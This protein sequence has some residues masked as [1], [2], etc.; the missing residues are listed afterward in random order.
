MASRNLKI[1]FK[2]GMERDLPIGKVVY[3]KSGKPCIYFDKM[4]NGT[5]RVIVNESIIPDFDAID[6]IELD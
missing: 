6:T 3:S 4:P 5:W 2:N 1:K